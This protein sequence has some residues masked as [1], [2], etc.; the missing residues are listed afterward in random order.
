[1][2]VCVCVLTIL[3]LERKF[4]LPNSRGE[5]KRGEKKRGEM[6]MTTVC[7]IQDTSTVTFSILLTIKGR[8]LISLEPCFLAPHMIRDKFPG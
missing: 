6:S 4:V 2:C 5:E 1:M 8:C 3:S 7:C